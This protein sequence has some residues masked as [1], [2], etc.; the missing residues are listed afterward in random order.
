MIA[1]LVTLI[2]V[3]AIA[4]VVLAVILW[5]KS[6]KRHAGYGLGPAPRLLADEDDDDADDEE[7][8]PD[9][10]A[11][12]L[13]AIPSDS[14]LV[15]RDGSVI[16]ATSGAYELGIVSNDALCDANI[17]RDVEKAFATGEPVTS[18]VVTMTPLHFIDIGIAPAGNPEEFDVYDAGGTEQSPANDSVIPVGT[19]GTEVTATHLGVKNP[20]ARVGSVARRNWLRTKVALL[21]SHIAVVLIM[22]VSQQVR[23]SRVRNDF[24][25]NVTDRLGK[26]MNALEK[27]GADLSSKQLDDAKVERDAALVS[28]YSNEL[29]KLIDD[30]MLLLRAQQPIEPTAGN[31][32][33]LSAIVRDAVADEM[34]RASKKNIR[35][36]VKADDALAVHGDAELLSGVIAK[37]VDNAISYSPRGATVTVAVTRSRDADADVAIVRVIDRGCGIAPAEQPHIFERFWRGSNQ[38]NREDEG[39]G[40]GL[41]IAKHVALAHNG[42]LSV[43]SQP[44]AGSTFSF[45]VPLAHPNR[46]QPESKPLDQNHQ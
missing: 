7:D 25:E 21:D 12:L 31:V 18:E 43:W 14:A 23:F 13:S 6:G 40:L 5:R 38:A 28:Q 30:L 46:N 16:R 2:A 45:V 9:E 33:S 11:A 20:V 32:I 19:A 37:L 24:I 17:A 22:N 29:G 26:P 34:L 4:V 10:V 41:A 15:A 39:T 1:I 8:I 42:S 3:L 44:G 27:L 36:V 35:L